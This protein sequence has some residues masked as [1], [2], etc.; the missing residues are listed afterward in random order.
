[1][2]GAETPV[3]PLSWWVAVICFAMCALAFYGHFAYRRPGRLGDSWLRHNY[4]NEHVPS[5]IRYAPLNMLPVSGVFGLWGGIA[6]MS[7]LFGNSIT[8]YV[9]AILAIL[10]VIAAAIGVKR[11]LSGYPDETKPQWLIDEERKRSTPN[12]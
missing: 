7:H 12:E 10:S 8:N 4:F 11:H 5:V 1:M 9:V 3:E 6:A 2:N